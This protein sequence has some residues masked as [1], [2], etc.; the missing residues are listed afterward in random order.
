MFALLGQN[1][2]GWAVTENTPLIGAK[3]EGHERNSLP[4]STT[5]SVA[6]LFCSHP[7][8]TSHRLPHRYPLLKVLSPHDTNPQSEPCLFFP[9]YPL[10]I[11]PSPSPLPGRAGK[12]RGIQFEITSWGSPFYPR[13]PEGW[14][15]SSMV[16]HLPCMHKAQGSVPL[17]SKKK[18]K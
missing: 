8:L 12:E 15:R 4:G 6:P 10:R 9:V 14:E 3:I 1:S 2:L 5:C 16:E 17:L 7:S 11:V 13:V 18:E